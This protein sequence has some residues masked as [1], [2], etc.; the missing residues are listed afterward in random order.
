PDFWFERLYPADR[1][2]VLA[3]LAASRAHGTPFDM[4]YRLV[5]RDGQIRWFHDLAD[6]VR[7][8]NGE[9]EF[10]QG[11]MLDITARKDAEEEQARLLEQLEAERAWLRTVIDRSPVGILLAEGP[12]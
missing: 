3:A 11:V 7:S 1:D 4:E 10:L 8:A 6:V 9:P 2:R 5:A 12:K